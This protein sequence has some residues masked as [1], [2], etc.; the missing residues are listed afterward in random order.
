[1][2]TWKPTNTCELATISDDEL[3]ERLVP[4]IFVPSNMRHAVDAENDRVARELTRRGFVRT[5]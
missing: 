4:S 1:M 5:R 2:T 3:F